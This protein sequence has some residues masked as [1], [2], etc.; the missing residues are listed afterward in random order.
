MTALYYVA[1]EC[2]HEGVSLGRPAIMQ[3]VGKTVDS[4]TFRLRHYERDISARGPKAIGN[5]GEGVA[6]NFLRAHGIL[7][8]AQ[9]PYRDERGLP[10]LVDFYDCQPRIAYEVK[11]GRF[12]SSSRND[13]RVKHLRHALKSGQFKH[14]IFLNIGFLGHV[15]FADSISRLV[16]AFQVITL[17]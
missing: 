5:Y 11:T 1:V 16:R 10:H 14:V 12:R 13:F 4:S 15:G 8:A 7:P 2:F 9:Y 3:F 6:E 17:D